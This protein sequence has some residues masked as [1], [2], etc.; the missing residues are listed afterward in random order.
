MPFYY[1]KYS[2]FFEIALSLYKFFKILMLNRRIL[3]I[4][5]FKVIYEYSVRG[6]MDLP[7]LLAELDSSNEA[8][9]D[10]YLYMLS[11]IPAVTKVA[12]ERIAA[13]M[14]KLHPTEEDLNPNDKFATNALAALLDEDSDFQKQVKARKLSWDNYDIMVK[15]ILDA[16]MA[17]PYYAEYMQNPERSLA[18]DCRL[19]TKIFENNLVDDPDLEGILEEISMYWIDDLA[20]AL[21][22]C[23]RTLSDL[24]KGRRWRLPELYQSDVIART[25]PSAKVSSDRDF[26][27]KLVTA[28]ATGYERFFGMITEAVPD[29]DKDRLF[30]TDMALI[31]LSLA[32]AESFD[33]I[34]LK[35]TMNEYVEISKFYCAPKSRQ[36]VNG[37]MDKLIKEDEKVNK[38]NA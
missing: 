32:E 15:K 25:D 37:L 17:E 27:R 4:K 20:Y 28:A 6:G 35:V 23:C 8:V 36:F 21:T 7:D 14:L 10:L 12:A 22:W 1:L 16:V 5:A 13:P 30:A 26:V 18:E 24:A 38:I 34:P 2:K 11:L 3:R 33:D 29:W 9:R 19:F 31:A